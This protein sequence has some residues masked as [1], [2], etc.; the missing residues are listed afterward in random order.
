VAGNR[1]K[2]KNG[3]QGPPRA[4]TSR[5]TKPGGP[6]LKRKRRRIKDKKKRAWAVW[7][8]D[9][10]NTAGDSECRDLSTKGRKKCP[11]SPNVGREGSQEVPS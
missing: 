10:T 7:T 3:C 8:Y 11:S 2:W 1:G 9:D 5:T 6:T 4:E